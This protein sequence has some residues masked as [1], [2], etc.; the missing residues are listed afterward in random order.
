MLTLLF[1]IGLVLVFIGLIIGKKSRD[2]F[3]QPLPWV[4]IV[5]GGVIAF[6]CIILLI[7]GGV[8]LSQGRVIDNKIAMYQ[9]E[10]TRIETTVTTTVEKYLEHEYQIFD[11]LQGE[12]IQTLLVVY[13]EINSNELVKRQVEIFVENNNKIKELKEQKL[14][15]E[16]WKFWVY[17]GG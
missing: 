6:V 3:E 5:L 14:N 13:P 15:I 4:N 17:F 11:S 1:V 8:T 7:E 16:V 2:E 10:N 12:D 9:E